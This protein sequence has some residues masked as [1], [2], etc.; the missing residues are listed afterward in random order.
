MRR[1]K[2]I[3]LQPPEF[4]LLGFLMRNIGHVVTRTMLLENVRDLHFDPRTSIVV[5][6]IS[7]LCSKSDRGHD[8]ELIHTVRS[9]GYSLRVE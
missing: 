1:G 6:H 8:I 2:S 9:V 3:E 5:T 4:R 7:H